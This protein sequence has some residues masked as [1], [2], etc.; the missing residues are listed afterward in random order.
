MPRQP[1]SKFQFLILA[2]F[3]IL[4]ACSAASPVNSPAS[5]VESYLQSLVKRNLN[6][7]VNA[8]CAAWE[9]QARI[10]YNSFEAVKLELQGVQCKEIGQ[11]SPYTL[12][13]CT[14]TIVANYGNED[15]QIDVADRS[16]QVIQEGGEW[17]MCGY[18]P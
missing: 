17:K 13:A 15:L 7:A 8:S 11:D 14:G 16:Y 3:F 2:L 18:H 4:A 12:V 10:E 9:E 1:L 6:G 5:A